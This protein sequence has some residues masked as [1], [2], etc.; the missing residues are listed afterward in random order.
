M[1][2]DLGPDPTLVAIRRIATALERIATTLEHTPKQVA[3]PPVEKVWM[4][5][6]DWEGYSAH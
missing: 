3:C 5:R 4:E 6:P 2:N 1:W